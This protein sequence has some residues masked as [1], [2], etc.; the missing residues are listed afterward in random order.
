VLIPVERGP[1]PWITP[2]LSSDRYAALLDTVVPSL[3]N[4]NGVVR[5]VDLEA[6]KLLDL[7]LTFGEVP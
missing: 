7:E 3:V 6:G 1:T 2:T 4:G 5:I